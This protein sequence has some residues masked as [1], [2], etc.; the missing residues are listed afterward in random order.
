MYKARIQRRSAFTLIEILMVAAILAVLAAFAV[1][2]LMKQGVRAK[3]DL[4]RATILRNGPIAKGLTNFRFDVGRYPETSEGLEALFEI[5]SGIDE[6]SGKWQGPYMEG[7]LE[8]LRDPW[9]QE[10]HYVSPGEFH[11]ESYDLWSDGLDGED[12]TDDDIKNWRET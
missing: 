9:Q 6:D 12:G 2:A 11:E 4:C 1:P 7:T 5:P 10:F 8:E 3:M